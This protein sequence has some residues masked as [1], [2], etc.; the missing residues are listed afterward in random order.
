M[1]FKLNGDYLQVWNDKR[2]RCVSL[3]TAKHLVRAFNYP[4]QTK[5]YRDK[6]TKFYKEGDNDNDQT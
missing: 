1:K 4:D 3:G 6:L 2:T 5:K